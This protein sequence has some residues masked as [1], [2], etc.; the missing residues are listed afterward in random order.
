MVT[1]PIDGRGNE[2][3]TRATM[4]WRRV[5][6]AAWFVTAVA[7]G[8]HTSGA[9]TLC[10]NQPN[11]CAT[12]QSSVRAAECAEV[13]FPGA[14]DAA[15]GLV[16][17]PVDGY[18]PDVFSSRVEPCAGRGSGELLFP[19][20]RCSS[21]RECPSGSTC[22][23]N[24]FCLQEAEC[25]EDSQCG[26]GETCA[27]AGSFAYT[28]VVGFNQC[29]PAECRS[30]ADCGGYSCGVSNVDACGSLGGL[31]CH[32]ETD[33]CSLHSDCGDRDQLCGYDALGG[34]WRCV[35]RPGTCDSQ[36]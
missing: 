30:D 20:T 7:C 31:F 13:V 12:E 18:P 33:E 27:C 1:K 29:V 19:S 21:D 15:T 10:A 22:G 26:T 23:P 11:G 14:Q 32:S 16:A 8:G 4:S 2:I 6:G 3:V 24:L 25:E 5:S 36:L 9:T 35:N 17:C 34:K 28:G